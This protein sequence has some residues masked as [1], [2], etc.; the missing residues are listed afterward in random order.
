MYSLT[1]VRDA[2]SDHDIAQVRSFN[3]LVT[4]QVGALQDRFLDRRPLGEARMLFRSG[5]AA[6]RRATSRTAPPRL[7]LLS[8]LIRSLERDGLV[9]AHDAADSRA[10]RLR[11]TPEDKSEIRDLDRM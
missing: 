8:Q 3:R 6:R 4:G 9:P 10:T 11:L 2:L 5:R 1:Q 7:R